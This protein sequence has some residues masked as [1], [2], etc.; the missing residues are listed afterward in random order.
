MG[1]WFG[2]GANAFPKRELVLSPYDHFSELLGPYM[3]NLEKALQTVWEEA[4]T[5]GSV[6]SDLSVGWYNF[7]RALTLIRTADGDGD[8]G[9]TARLMGDVICA[10][11]TSRQRSVLTAAGSKS[12]NRP[13]DTI[14]D[15]MI[16][17][18]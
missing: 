8:M 7:G 14:D 3:L 13:E 4:Y 12:K 2:R 11:I 6:L 17:R 5:L 16:G 15:Y 1:S 10:A 18:M 9:A